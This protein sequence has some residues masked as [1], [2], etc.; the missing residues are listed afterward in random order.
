MFELFP[1]KEIARIS[2]R[3]DQQIAHIC[4]Y[5]RLEIFLISQLTVRQS[6]PE[7]TQIRIELSAPKLSRFREKLM[8]V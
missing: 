7:F 5:E 6:I 4:Y 1:F 2:V 8:F 3:K